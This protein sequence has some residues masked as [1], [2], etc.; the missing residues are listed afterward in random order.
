[1][2]RILLLIVFTTFGSIDLIAQ[3][4]IPTSP[5]V[6]NID[7]ARFRNDEQSGYL[8]IYYGFHPHLLT[9][10]WSEGKYRAGVHLWTRVRDDKTEAFAVNERVLLPVEITDTTDV[11]LRFPFITQAGYVLP[12]GDYTLEVVAVDSLNPSR[13]DSVS[14]VINIDVHR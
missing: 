13:R 7:Y 11:S 3:S 10:Q 1:M 8:E 12:L 5:F 2:R 14:L 6:T 9:H 4:I